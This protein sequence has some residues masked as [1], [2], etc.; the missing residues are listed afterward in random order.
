MTAVLLKY[1]TVNEQFMFSILFL[2]LSAASDK[3]INYYLKA[4]FK[5]KFKIQITY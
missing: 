2:V 4:L 5:F 3:N 1:F